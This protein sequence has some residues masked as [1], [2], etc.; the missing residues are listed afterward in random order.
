MSALSSMQSIVALLLLVYAE[1]ANLRTVHVD[2][3]VHFA[4]QRV[5]IKS[6]AFQSALDAALAT[7]G[8]SKEALGRLATKG[9]NLVSLSDAI[10]NVNLPSEVSQLV[11]R[12]EQGAQEDSS[13]SLGLDPAA[14]DRAVLKLNDMVMKAYMKLDE[15][16]VECWEFKER[17]R[18]TFNQVVT[19]LSRIGGAIS[20]LE[21]LQLKASSSISEID[22]NTQKTEEEMAQEKKIFDNQWGIDSADLKIKQ[23][24]LEV[25]EFM[26]G[27]TQC[28]GDWPG[29]LIQIGSG[30]A[31]TAQTSMY[32]SRVC[33]GKINFNDPRLENSTKH[34]SPRGLKMLENA[35]H[36][37]PM[38]DGGVDAADAIAEAAGVVINDDYDDGDGPV[39]QARALLQQ[40]K[41]GGEPDLMGGE[42]KMQPLTPAPK[43]VPPA[44]SPPKGKVQHKCADAKP[45]CAVLH[46]VFATLWGEMKDLVEAKQEEM[47]ANMAAWKKTEGN[48]NSQLSMMALQMGQTQAVLAEATSTKATETDEQTQKVLEKEALEKEYKEY[49]N[50]CKHRKQYIFW[51]EICGVIRVRGEVLKQGSEEQKTAP[52]TDCELSKWV[53][54]ECSSPC[55]PKM[56]GGMQTLTREVITIN[57]KY[58]HPCPSLH[59]EKKCNEFKCPVN[60][61]LTSWT[62][63][64][65]CTKECGGGVESRNRKL[66]VKPK[67]GGQSCD[68]LEESESCNSFSCDRDCLLHRWTKW[69]P[70]SKA[71][72]SGFQERF[73]HIKRPVRANGFCFSKMSK[74]RY[75][76][77]KCNAQHC[78]GD[79]ECIAVM[80][81]I[82][83]IDASG[84]ISEKGF[85][86]M[87]TFAQFLLSR[88]KT[89]AY[90]NGAVK[91][92]V[93]QFG[94]GKL[95]DV[96]KVVSDAVTINPLS[97]KLDEVKEAI[98]GMHWSKG[99]TNM[100]QAFMKASAILQ[101]S[102]RK[103][104]A[105]TFLMITDGKPSFIFQ[106]DKAVATYK[107]RGRVVIVQVKQY[108]S[109]DTKELMKR[110]AS[111]PWQ[112]NY[113]LVPGGKAGLKGDYLHYA[114]KVL[115]SG[116]PRA[117]S[118]K[119]NLAM[120]METGY[121]KK[122]EGWNC[123]DPVGS[124]D[125]ENLDACSAMMLE[126]DGGKSFAYAPHDLM[127]GG[128]CLIYDK[129][130]EGKALLP[131][132]TYNTYF[133]F[134]GPSK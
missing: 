120:N 18:G 130:C 13:S 122:F 50:E 87:K 95:D 97:S 2:N 75:A 28:K 99:F 131:N 104:A 128:S 51:T 124:V 69:T 80:D 82:I 53:P 79:E 37:A 126:F 83:G 58:G 92:A 59:W 64:S 3:H 12:E 42:M 48:F 93:I 11:A 101:R 73:R 119:A 90:G 38:D 54:G 40:P 44:K 19:D 94:N 6:L 111:K 34:L 60:C 33:D 115:V 86:I 10:K 96:T 15:K 68:T 5:H 57:T 134:E 39:P 45:D 62:G 16:F 100:A 9:A 61:V 46:D 55:D 65:K 125:V 70:C 121:E 127:M 41:K 98:K 35:Y 78:V 113:I 36:R 14:V 47:D 116:C 103:M 114:D 31:A 109:K 129:K 7:D 91:V 66:I 88:F 132:S 71:C 123:A 102:P 30:S 1:G 117:E 72:D 52:A 77:K 85:G 63:W 74:Q 112:S 23:N 76:K 110:Y 21:R 27:V 22:E 17:N 20:D 49:M 43:T 4:E 108:A 106:T 107:G 89:E 84:S 24:D 118:P 56:K 25:A 105:G 29:K 26:L 133:P 67:D 8:K 81:M 32:G